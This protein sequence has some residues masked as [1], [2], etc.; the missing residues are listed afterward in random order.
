MREFVLSLLLILCLFSLSLYDQTYSYTPAENAPPV[1]QKADIVHVPADPRTIL[2]NMT[3]EE[4]LAQMLLASCHDDESAIRAAQLKV[5][6]ICLFAAS[7]ENKT[8][9]E[10]IN[11]SAALQSQADY[12]LLLAVD[13]EGGSVCRVSSNPL[14]RSERFPSPQELYTEGGLPLVRGDAIEKSKLL[15]SLGINVNL[16][17]VCDVPQSED[18]YIFDRSYSC[19]ARLCA[20]YVSLTVSTMKSQGIG[21]VLKHFP[22]Y[23]SNLDTHKQ[24]SRD[25]R[26]FAAFL[27]SD[28]LPFTAGIEAGADAVLVCHNIVECMDSELPASLS[29]KVMAVLRGRLGFRGVIISD[30]L[31]MR[32]VAEFEGEHSAAVLAVIAGIDLICGPDFEQYINELS[33]AVEIGLIPE[34]QIDASVFRILLWKVELGLI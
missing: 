24:V 32:A 20:N 13:E 23:G 28:F 14:L 31:S 3:L 12:P 7:F 16:A 5:G 11:F 4:K 33:T 18:N 17:P 30:D 25:S 19:D 10:L 27:S 2:S 8:R 34:A 1:S 22:G 6:G 26:P 15:L 21:S 29:P 9:S